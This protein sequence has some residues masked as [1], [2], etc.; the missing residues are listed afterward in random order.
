MLAASNGLGERI[1]HPSQLEKL[2]HVSFTDH[3]LD[4]GL[5]DLTRGFEEHNRE[6]RRPIDIIAKSRGFVDTLLR[7][8]FGQSAGGVGAG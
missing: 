6:V 5:A 2:V 1:Y 7:L 3:D 4:A 8:K